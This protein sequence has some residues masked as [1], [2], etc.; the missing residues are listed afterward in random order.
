MTPEDVALAFAG[1]MAAGAGLFVLLCFAPE[2]GAFLR[3]LL[4]R[5]PW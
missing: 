1:T 4:G 5:R 2:I 3:K